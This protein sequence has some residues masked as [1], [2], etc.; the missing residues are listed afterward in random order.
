MK[1]LAFVLFAAVAAVSPLRAQGPAPVVVQAASPA[2]PVAT[3]A[4]PAAASA[5]GASALKLL[6]QVK[7]ANDEVL[8]KQAATL[9][10]LDDMEKSAEQIKIYTKRG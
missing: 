4:A 7:A 6:L 2:Q 3:N 5:A 9:Q 10:Q 8:K 1:R